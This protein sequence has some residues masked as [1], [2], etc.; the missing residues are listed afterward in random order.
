MKEQ[1]TIEVMRKLSFLCILSRLHPE[2]QSEFPVR[3]SASHMMSLKPDYSSQV[4]LP[5]QYQNFLNMDF[6]RT[7]GTT[8]IKLTGM[9]VS[10]VSNYNGRRIATVPQDKH[11]LCPSNSS[12]QQESF[13]HGKTGLVPRK[14]IHGSATRPL[15][16]FFGRGLETRLLPTQFVHCCLVTARAFMPACLVR[17]IP[18]NKFLEVH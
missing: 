10:P 3:Q 18:P 2:R 11:V 4:N 5:I 1:K 17:L 6:S 8:A 13:L 7:V 15:F 14:I 16:R 9:T 12:L